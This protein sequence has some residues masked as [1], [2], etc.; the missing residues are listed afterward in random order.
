M[1]SLRRGGDVVVDGLHALLGQR[2][3]V[4]DLLLAD[5]AEARIYVDHRRAGLNPLPEIGE[6]GSFG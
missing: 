3:G 4:F 5:P 1:K 6:V 2:S